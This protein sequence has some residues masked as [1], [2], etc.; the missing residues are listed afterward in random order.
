ME[1]KRSEQRIKKHLKAEVH[2]SDGMTYSSSVDISHG[3]IFLSTPD[4]LNQEDNVTLSIRVS[5]NEWLDIDGTIKWNRDETDDVKAGMGIQFRDLSDHDK[6]K[7]T[8][9]LEQ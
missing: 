2:T 8:T 6:E 7:I 1:E 9:L 3:G 4:P 5:D